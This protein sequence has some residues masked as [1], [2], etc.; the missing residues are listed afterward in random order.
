MILQLELVDQGYFRQD[1][2][3]QWPQVD[4]DGDGY[5]TREEYAQSMG[6][7][8]WWKERGKREFLS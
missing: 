7:G 2:E 4:L 8:G 5:V 3:Q 1:L 6:E